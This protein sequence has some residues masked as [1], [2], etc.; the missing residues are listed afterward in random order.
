M[1]K[2]RVV[3]A[4]ILLA[5]LS[6]VLYSGS[7]LAFIVAVTAFHTAAAW[8]NMRLFQSRHSWLWAGL[9]TLVFLFSFYQFDS[10]Q[11]RMLF[12]LC[13]A[14]WAIRF[15]PSLAIGLPQTDSFGS[16]LLSITY[17]VAILGCFAAM[18][19]LYQVSAAYLFS[20]MALVWIAD[21]GAYFAGRAFG[22]HKLAPSISP[23]KTWEGAAGGLA[24]VLLFGALSTLH[25]LLAGTF[26][27]SIQQKW[28]YA[29]M[30]AVLALITVASI[31]GDLF[32]SQLKRRAGMKDSSNL[33]PGHGGVL[34]R[35]DA[36]IP[37]LPLA[38]LLGARL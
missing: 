22:R 38:V 11:M 34:D 24:S 28:G 6:A 15:I 35:I 16:R 37:A 12:S 31:F 36:L 20:V 25:P 21:I 29:G 32:E 30:V 18:A 23:G 2:T 8:E 33:L 27:A 3:T 17:G 13:V 14:I 10:A 4:V 26:S 9:W 19:V 5:I 1:L 7:L